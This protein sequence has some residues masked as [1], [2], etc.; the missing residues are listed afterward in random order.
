[1]KTFSQFIV[2]QLNFKASFKS[3]TLLM[4]IQ[5]LTTLH[6]KNIFKKEYS[7]DICCI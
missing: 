1:M 7:K 3:K 5:K 6:L 2:N 4:E